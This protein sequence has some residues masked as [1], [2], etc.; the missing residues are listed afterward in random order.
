MPCS[1]VANVVPGKGYS[2][3]DSAPFVPAPATT[4]PAGQPEQNTVND[5]SPEPMTGTPLSCSDFP[6]DGYD[7]SKI[8][9]TKI[10]KYFTLADLSCGG[11][12]GPFKIIN[13][14]L[15]GYKL[16]TQSVSVKG[17]QPQ[18]YTAQSI[19]CHLSLLAKNLLDPIYEYARSQSWDMRITSGFRSG[20][21]TGGGDHGRG[22]AADVTFTSGGKIITETQRLQLMQWANASLGGKIR[23]MLFEKVTEKD[24]GGWIHFSATTPSVGAAGTKVAVL[25]V[26]GAPSFRPGFPGGPVY[27]LMS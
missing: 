19:A 15:R 11:S 12:S 20:S 3:P 8:Y 1:A 18:V 10:S 5:A 9:A 4:A 21:A 13:S 26:N 23:Q 7:D 22:L 14:S 17:S 16:V 27:T 2:S 6:A 24:N 25:I